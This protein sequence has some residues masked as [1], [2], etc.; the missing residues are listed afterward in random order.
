MKI[1]IVRIKL[2]D[3]IDVKIT[4]KRRLIILLQ[5]ISPSVKRLVHAGIGF[6][7]FFVI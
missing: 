4:V 6:L 1:K 7:I 2:K 5:K 3:N